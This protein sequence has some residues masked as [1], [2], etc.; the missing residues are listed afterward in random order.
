MSDKENNEV[1]ML[2]EAPVQPKG[3]DALLRDAN[4]GVFYRGAKPAGSPSGKSGGESY[5]EV[6]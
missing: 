2:T 5:W 1:E 3:G 4:T 6:R